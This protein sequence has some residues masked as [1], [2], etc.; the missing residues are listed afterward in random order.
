MF[1]P[2]TG[3]IVLLAQVLGGHSLAELR[4]IPGNVVAL[5]P[6]SRSRRSVNDIQN[7]LFHL[8][9][10][11]ALSARCHISYDRDTCHPLI[12]PPPQRV[13]DEPEHSPLQNEK[14]GGPVGKAKEAKLTAAQNRMPVEVG[15]RITF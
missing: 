8:L 12:V 9:L 6:R 1:T 15:W 2:A 11:S 3:Q 10:R 7:R 5:G 13:L 4:I 14:V